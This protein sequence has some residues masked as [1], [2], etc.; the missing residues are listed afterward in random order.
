MK[1][2]NGKQLNVRS[3]EAYERAHRLAKR[4][5]T[6]TQDVVVQALRTLEGDHAPDAPVSPEQAIAN[7]AALLDAVR[8]ATWEAHEGVQRSQRDDDDWLYDENGL[9]H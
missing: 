5:G 3:N 7:V 9:P 2:S 8:Q 4:M 1:A 6:T